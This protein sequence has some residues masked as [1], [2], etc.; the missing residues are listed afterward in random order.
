MSIA[1]RNEKTAKLDEKN[2][3]YTA[4]DIEILEGLEHVRKR[5]GMYIGGTDIRG[6]HQLVTEVVDNSVDEAMA[7][8][9]D[10]ILIV[11]GADGSISVEDNGRGIPVEPHPKYPNRSTLEIIM[12]TLGAGGKFGGDGYKQGSSGLHGV[13]V[14]AVNALAAYCRVEVKRGGK[15]YAQEYHFGKPVDSVKVV[16]SAV[17]T[18]V[19][20]KFLPDLSIMETSDFQFDTLAQRF[21]EMA[22][23]NRGLTIKLV[24]EREGREQEYSFYFDGGLK[25]FVRHLNQNKNVIMARP[26]HL[27][28]K[29]DKTIVEVAIQYNDSYNETLFSFANGINTVDGGSHVTGFRAALTRTLNEYGRKSGHLKEA[30]ANLT[31]DDVREGLTAAISVKLPEA[32]FEGQTKG[33][34]NNADVRTQVENVVTEALLKYLEET[35]AEGKRIIEKCVNAARAK[36]A[37]RKARELVRRK[38]SLDST[39]PGKLAD[40][41]ERRPDRCELYLVEGDSAGGCFSG[42]TKVALADGRS[43]SFLE[44]ID[45]EAAGIVH[46]AY[47]IR[48]DGKVGLERI[49][50]VRM[51][52]AGAEVIKVTLDNGETITCTPDHRFMLRDG[53]YKAA[54]ELTPDD[55]LMPLYRKMSDMR[56][57]GITIQDYEMVWDPRSDSWLFT[58]KLADWYNRWRGVYAKSDGN[59]CHH[60][61]FN[62]HNNNPTNLRRLPEEDHLA[63]HRV[64]VERT[65]HRPEIKEKSRAVRRGEAYRSAM[66]MRMRQAGTRE[67]LSSQAKAQWEDESY[68]AYM[69]GKWLEFYQTNETYRAE[70]QARLD[71]SQRAHWSDESNRLAQADRVQAYFQAHPEARVELSQKAKVQWQDEELLSWRSQT[72]CK[73]WTPDFRERRQAAL[74]Q[75][76]YRKTMAALKQFETKP[77]V[78]DVVAYAAYR[79]AMKDMSLLRIDKFCK[80]YFDGDV[81]LMLGAVARYNHRIVSVER[82]AEPIEVYDLE[83]PGT[84]NFALASGIF[85]H[86]SAKQGRDRHFQA[87]LPLRGKILN[88]E[89]ARLDRMLASES[90]KDIITALGTGIGETI[91]YDKLRYGRVVLMTDADVDGSHIRTLLLTFFYRHM[92][93]L[94]Q[95]GRLYI[96]QPPLY[97]IQ[98]GKQRHYVYSEAEKDEFLARLGEGKN[99]P[100]NR[101]KGLGEMDPEELWDTTMNPA[102]RTILQVNIEDALKADETFSMLMGDEVMPRKHFIESHAKNVKNLDI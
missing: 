31:G 6:L 97:R 101:Y 84:H 96:A 87:I 11:I 67:I 7:G 8:V 32:Q 66:S 35:P 29:V 55:S 64:H 17:G 44:L 36:D 61:D 47:T 85:V 41:S 43:L 56:E 86:N 58:H 34:L 82:V 68:K 75:T 26:V 74:K 91:T 78:V 9:C 37:A 49:T 23:L 90:I 50:N 38:D 10:Q 27:E 4:K 57:P 13:G 98:V 65:L 15:L 81:S 3:S 60:V 24:D 39:L 53:S 73:Q 46:Y 22:Y 69:A 71:E 72:T 62:K 59:H 88:V 16:G 28:K 94:I 79:L 48:R 76:Y 25:S 40:C 2:S 12:T 42:D 92:E 21:R 45:E 83:V 52:K 95:D 5:P 33:K 54:A 19:R 14:S 70:N 100:V 51:T 30:D 80:R 102:T 93:Q 77:G 89:R 1:E 20:T 99:P 18:G 63:L